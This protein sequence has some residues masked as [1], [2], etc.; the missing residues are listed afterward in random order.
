MLRIIIPKAKGSLAHIYGQSTISINEIHTPITIKMQ[1]KGA[2]REIFFGRLDFNVMSN[3][4]IKSILK[5]LP[6]II[7]C[8][9]ILIDSNRKY[10]KIN[11]IIIIQRKKQMNKILA[12]LTLV[13]FVT[14]INTAQATLVLNQ[15]H[16]ITIE[17]S[18]DG[19]QRVI[20]VSPGL[21][22]LPDGT[23]KVK[24]P[25]ADSTEK[26]APPQEDLQT[27]SNDYPSKEK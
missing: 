25:S 6:P 26:K 15:Q 12:F 24:K 7:F 21:E 11:Y 16:T 23:I 27:N 19:T 5:N 9:I 20:G 3:K 13:F 1:S 10:A 22:L 14:Q 18:P 17:T 8:E 2:K 4:R